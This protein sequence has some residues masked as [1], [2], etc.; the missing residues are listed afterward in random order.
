[1]LAQQFHRLVGIAVVHHRAIVTCEDD[2][3]IIGYSLALQRI[4]HSTYGI[5]KLQYSIATR[6]HATLTDEA[7]VRIAWHMDIVRAQVKEEGS[8]GILFYELYRM[9]SDTIGDVFILPSR[10]VAT[11]HISDARYTVHNSLIVPMI[12]AW[13]QLGE[14]LGMRLSQWFTLERH[15]IAHLDRI[16]RVEPHH[17]LILHP[18]TRYTI[19]RSRHDVRVVEPD[20]RRSRCDVSVPIL[21]A[22][23]VGQSQVPL[24]HGSRHVALR[25]EEVGHGLLLGADNHA[26][27]ARCH[28]RI[29]SSPAIVARE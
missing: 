28:A 20:V 29:V 1:M 16:L 9:V 5:V 21:R 8:A 22:R 10:P 7:W 27:I 11:L 13:V 6:S 17:T 25:T 24:S 2:E 15:V 3:R 23:R 19:A 14:Q 26:R 4:E 18:H 12:H